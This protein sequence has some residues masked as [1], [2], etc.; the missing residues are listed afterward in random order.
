MQVSYKELKS[1]IGSVISE[2]LGNDVTLSDGSTSQFGSPEHIK[3]MQTT[4]H[5]LNNLKKQHKYGSATRAKLADAG[6]HI[7]RI[8]NKVAPEEPKTF[9]QLEG[10][11]RL[12]VGELRKMIRDRI[13]E[14]EGALKMLD[15]VELRLILS[16]DQKIEE[17]VTK[18]RIVKGV[19]TVN[20]T[21]PVV[22]NPSGDRVLDL[23]VS[24]DSQGIDQL[25]YI[26]ALA[27]VMKKIESVKTIVIKNLN[28][29][30]LR[31]ATGKRKLVY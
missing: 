29:Q 31:D 27:H 18:I 30:P 23:L 25:E 15:V 24:F 21:N 28:Q 4:L 2:S 12:P 20:Q 9:A 8:L 26:D 11:V 22:R 3:D 6:S 10:N 5:G 17:I 13:N 19:A 7:K 16:K 14:A 1:I